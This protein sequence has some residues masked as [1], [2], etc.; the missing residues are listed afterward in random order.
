MSI[1]NNKPIDTIRDGALKATIW[2]NFG[3]NGNFYSVELSRTY[4]DENGDYH[5]SHSFSGSDLLK[6]AR[7]SELAYSRVADL[8]DSDRHPQEHAA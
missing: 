3:D 5:D 2:K 8:R 6:I 1:A 4:R 7:L